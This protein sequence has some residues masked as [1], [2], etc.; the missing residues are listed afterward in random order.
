MKSAASHPGWA[1]LFV[2][3][4]GCGDS[5][6]PQ[7]G[8]T[9]SDDSRAW[10]TDVTADRGI[11]RTAAMWPDGHL[12]VPEI[13]SAGLA[14]FDYDNDGDLDIYRSATRRRRRGS[15]RWPRSPP[16]GSM[17][18]KPTDGSKT[19]P[20]KAG[21]P[22]PVMAPAWRWA[23]W[24]TTATSTST[25]PISAAMP[26]ISTTATARLRTP[27]RK[28]GLAGGSHWSTSCGF[29]D[30]DRDGD[31]DLFIVRFASFEPGR[32]C[33]DEADKP[34]YCNP[35][36]FYGEN[37]ALYRNNGDGTFTDVTQSA[38][39][40]DRSRGW[41]LLFVDANDD[42]WPDIFVANDGEA[43]QL[44][45][46]RKG[47]DFVEEAVARGVALNGAGVAEANMGVAAGDIAN[48]GK[49]DLFVT[50]L[51]GEKNTL[52][53]ATRPGAYQ[54]RSA[55]ANLAVDSLPYTGWG[56]VFC[57][58]DHDG[59]LDLA[60]VNG[61]VK[62]HAPDPKARLGAFW[63]GYAETN[64]LFKNDGKGKFASA[65]DHA[66]DFVREPRVSHALALGD[67]DND[68]DVDLV[69]DAADNSLRVYRNDALRSGTHWL[70]VR[71][72]T[73]RRDAHGRRGHIDAPIG[74]A[75][76]PRRSSDL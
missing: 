31:L 24:I 17:N 52:F 39:I 48:A 30:Y 2:V 51:R 60:I 72:M 46:N 62:R 49:W 53:A 61:R 1:V 32:K 76:A 40:V 34:E 5:A 10:F 67:L 13:T 38:G 18:S 16:I 59:D 55:T 33:L 66:G 73:G 28:F 43:N 71:P 65:P 75:I 6:A 21:S 63:N 47:G 12:M 45:I 29:F 22:I 26:S 36:S 57:D 23:T 42:G 69:A 19:F 64:L 27:R 7:N 35:Q 58:F 20:Q 70:L 9:S 11:P 74:S 41:G 54:D 8:A 37:D 50:H 44:W 14:L 4:L 15:E 3:A 68:G 25:S 56:C